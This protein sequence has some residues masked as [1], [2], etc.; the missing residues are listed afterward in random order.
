[1][2]LIVE[3][4][5][6]PFT[7]GRRTVL[8]TWCRLTVRLCRHH[9]ARILTAAR[10]SIA[11]DG[12]PPAVAFHIRRA[13]HFIHVEGAGTNQALGAEVEIL[14]HIHVAV[15]VIGTEGHVGILALG[16]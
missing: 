10:L 8:R 12:I 16:L 14:V 1:M 2:A 4:V 11:R 7:L 15:R 3:R 5:V 13:G 6:H 9:S